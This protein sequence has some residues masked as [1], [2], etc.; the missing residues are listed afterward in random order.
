[1][2]IT[3]QRLILNPVSM[4]DK[5]DI[6][7][8]FTSELT[9]F[10]PF[11]PTGNLTEIE[12]FILLSQQKIE[13]KKRLVL[14]IFNK[15]NNDFLGICEL[16]NI[17]KK[18]IEIGLWIKINEQEK[19]YGTEVVESLISFAEKNYDFD[20]LYYPV[21]KDNIASCKIPQKLGFKPF[22]S[23]E[24]YKSESTMLNIIEYRKL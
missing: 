3:T 12:N 6:C 8:E 11:N 2:K 7:R 13:N 18:E 24:K 14:S 19:G 5:F 20:Y 15:E 9:R 10:M 16:D 1:M 21:D 4:D 23:Y 17:D 22:R